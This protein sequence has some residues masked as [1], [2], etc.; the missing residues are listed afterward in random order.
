MGE[1]GGEA[2]KKETKFRGDADNQKT[3]SKTVLPSRAVLRFLQLWWNA[4]QASQQARCRIKH[5]SNNS[6][7][8]DRGKKKTWWKRHGS[9]PC[10]AIKGKRIRR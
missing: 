5:N 2:A 8:S 6:N 3:H 10:D 4:V 1:G 7:N 9:K